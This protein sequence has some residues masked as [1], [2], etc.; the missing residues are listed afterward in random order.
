MSP[1][2]ALLD[3]FVK[4]AMFLLFV[5]LPVGAYIWLRYHGTLGD[6]PGRGLG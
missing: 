4:L 6:P 3:T 2:F 5:F 1:P